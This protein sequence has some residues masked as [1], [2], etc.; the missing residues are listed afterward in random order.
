MYFYS[1][2]Y[3]IGRKHLILIDASVLF[4]FLPRQCSTQHACIFDRL[5]ID[6][7]LINVRYVP[8]R[9]PILDPWVAGLKSQFPLYSTMSYFG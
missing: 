5:L 4:A 7:L 1:I 2:I 6:R 8:E 9:G 3:T